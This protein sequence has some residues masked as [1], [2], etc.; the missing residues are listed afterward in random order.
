MLEID[1]TA[2]TFGPYAV[3]RLDGLTVMAPNAAPGDRLEVA[4]T[5]RRRELAFAKI[6][7]ILEA[8]PDRRMPPCPYLPQCGG[9][10]WQHLNYP[11]QLRA[12]AELIAAELRR[13]NIDVDPVSLVEP[14]PAEF[15]YRSRIRM[16]VGR[17]GELGFY[18]LSSNA[19][20]EID[21]CLVAAEGLRLPHAFASAIGRNL[22]EIEVVASGEREVLTAMMRKP[23]SAAELDR[24]RR[25][26]EQDASIQ[27]IILKAGRAREVI[28]DP[29]VTIS[30][31]DGL[32]LSVDADLF[33][34]VN[35]AQN[36]KLVATVME[37]ASIQPEMRV[38]DIFCGAGNLS[39]PAAR[40]GAIVNGIDADEL[41]IAAANANAQRLG[42]ADAKFIAGKA[43]EAVN[44]LLR[45]K[46][47]PDVTILD[48]PRV[49]AAELMEPLVKM[50][51]RAIIY[52]SCDMATLARDLRIL[53][54]SGYRAQRITALDFFPNTHHVEIAAHLLLT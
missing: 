45:A 29:A 32:E 52:V 20:V 26:I 49:G 19:L 27:G 4:I 48:P 3:A 37:M 9:C 50:H 7:R 46:Y 47:R 35:H 6:E 51:P 17:D 2:M 42:F 13:A 44:F 30:I 16:K 36:R 15:G 53:I 40:R 28:G 54:D 38:L 43:S 12:K 23:P 14:A 24:A 18:Q 22:D 33:S 11:A 39:L 8:G 21:R 10:D 25:S 41:A 34:Q 5:S 1:V 31:E